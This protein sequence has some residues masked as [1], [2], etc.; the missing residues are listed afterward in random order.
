MAIFS[1][2]KSLVTADIGGLMF[3]SLVNFDWIVSLTST[4]SA[5]SAETVAMF[6]MFPVF[7]TLNFRIILADAP[8]S[9]DSNLN[10]GLSPLKSTIQPS[11]ERSSSNETNLS[12]LNIDSS[13]ITLANTLFP[14]FETVM[15]NSV[16]LL[17]FL[18]TVLFKAVLTADKL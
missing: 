11:L 13:I 4:A 17:T 6:V 3:F 12:P 10:T 8:T 2:L 16:S 15:L 5:L 9:R 7:V 18:S 14:V 1:T